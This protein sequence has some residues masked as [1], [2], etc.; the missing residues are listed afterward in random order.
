MIK[1]AVRQFR[2]Q[3]L[4]A[5][6]ALVLVGIVL[7]ITGTQ[8]AHSYD[9]TVA[10]CQTYGDCPSVIA[11]LVG[12]DP[13]VQLSGIALILLPA[14]IG[15]FWGVP[16]VARELEAGTHRL[17]WTQSVTRTRWIIAK[18]GIVGL[19]SLAVTGLLSLMVTWWFS[20]IDRAMLNQY[21]VFDQR[22]IAP[23]GYAAFAFVLGVSAGVLIRR[24]L[25]AMAATA[26]AFIVIRVAMIYLI[27]PNL[28]APAQTNVVLSSASDLGFGPG[29]SGVE[30]FMA[31]SPTIPNAWVLSSAVVDTSGRAATDQ[32]LHDFLVG[33]CPSIASPPLRPTGLGNVHGPA[34]QAEFQ[35]CITALS[36]SFHEAV[37]YQ[38][39]DRYWAFQWSETAI[40]AGL[41]VGS[42]GFCC[43]WVRSRLS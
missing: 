27:G 37:T 5:A 14:V 25:P 31:G 22:D 10:G 13:L 39:A 34:N 21:S 6:S 33:A 3:G 8:L 29:S 12:T 15:I 1:L 38:P 9:T 26:V 20:P 24:T 16:L 17:V 28:F 30:T 2:T 43:W 32:T 42:A 7:A 23:I 19:A 18:L 41:A 35:D 4:V 40:F 36:T 11:A